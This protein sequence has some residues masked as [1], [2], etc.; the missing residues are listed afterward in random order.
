M[1]VAKL[2]LKRAFINEKIHRAYNE[3]LPETFFE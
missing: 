3:T 2:K 1:A